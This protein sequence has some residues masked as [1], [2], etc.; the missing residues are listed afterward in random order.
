M[1]A[2]VAPGGGPAVAS[3]LGPKGPRVDV[4][5]IPERPVTEQQQAMREACMWLWAN[6]SELVPEANPWGDPL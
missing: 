2:V 6:A 1:G 4:A 3:R 5:A